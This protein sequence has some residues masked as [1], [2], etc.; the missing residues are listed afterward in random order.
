VRKYDRKDRFLAWRRREARKA[1]N[2]EKRSLGS[3]GG[4]KVKAKKVKR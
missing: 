2:V 1:R 3:K 4:K